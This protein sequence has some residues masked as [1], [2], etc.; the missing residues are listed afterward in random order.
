MYSG[1]REAQRFSEFL[2]AQHKGKLVTSYQ[3]SKL[4]ARRVGVAAGIRSPQ[5]YRTFDNIEAVDLDGLPERFVLKPDRLASS[6]GVY[7]LVRRGPDQYWNM[8]AR[9]MV[10]TAQIKADTLAVIRRVRQDVGQTIIAEE[11]IVG[12]NGPD[13]V[14]YDYKAWMFG[15]EPRF[16]MQVD[17]N[18]RPHSLACFRGDFEPLP[19]YLVALTPKRQYRPACA[20]RTGRTY[21]RQPGPSRL[22]STTP[23]SASIFT[24]MGARSCWARS[25][26]ARDL[27]ISAASTG[28]RMNST[29]RWA[30]IGG[31]LWRS[32][33]RSSPSS[34]ARCR[35]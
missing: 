35:R 28:C 17:R 33:A 2:L 15:G 23:S 14:P 12:E 30:P 6:H 25:P 21:W 16:I 31:W 19:E 9:T 20:R 10:S 26:R 13:E 4:E 22:R 18:T 5:L 1:E 11:L 29:A 27:R 34:V 8:L 32:A 24:L 7:L 3:E